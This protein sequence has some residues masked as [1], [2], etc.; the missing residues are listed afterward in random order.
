MGG[1]YLIEVVWRALRY[2]GRSILRSRQLQQ[3]AHWVPVRGLVRSVTRE[4]S[5]VEVLITYQFNGG[6]FCDYHKRDLFWKAS[7][8]EYAS[9]FPP[10]NGCVIRISPTRPEEMVLFDNDQVTNSLA[11]A[12]RS[13]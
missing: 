13:K 8:E 12:V 5:L 10:E 3:A 4:E 9:R 7:A 1:E 11:S 6:Y 2:L